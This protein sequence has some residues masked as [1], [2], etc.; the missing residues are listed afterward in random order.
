MYKFFSK[1]NIYENTKECKKDKD[2][3]SITLISEIKDTKI[4]E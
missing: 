4:D 3:Y 1:I 2:P